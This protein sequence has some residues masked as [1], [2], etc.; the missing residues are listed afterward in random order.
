MASGQSKSP[1]PEYNMFEKTEQMASPEDIE[2]QYVQMTLHRQKEYRSKNN[3]R[4]MKR[5]NRRKRR[6]S[7]PPAPSK[8]Q[9]PPPPPQYWWMKEIMHSAVYESF[10]YLLTT[11]TKKRPQKA[12]YRHSA[13][14]Y[15]CC[16]I[17]FSIL[18]FIM[19]SSCSR[20]KFL[21]FWFDPR[22]STIMAMWFIK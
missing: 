3:N 9:S 14:I 22:E 10:V 8:R 18:K 13:C 1:S 11:T 4:S 7:P 17:I 16:P 20:N 19:K 5:T 21:Y 2:Y 15:C 6:K 12:L